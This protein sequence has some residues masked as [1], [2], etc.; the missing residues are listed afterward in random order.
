MYNTDAIEIIEITNDET[1]Y[2]F[3]DDIKKTGYLE[4]RL[5]SV[6]LHIYA[7]QVGEHDSAIIRVHKANENTIVKMHGKTDSK[8]SKKKK[9]FPS[10]SVT[11]IKMS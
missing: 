7:N 4:V 5:G 3:S 9:M 10:F 1:D 2:P 6:F 8:V 11:D